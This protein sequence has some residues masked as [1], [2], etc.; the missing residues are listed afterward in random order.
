MKV[1]CLQC[2]VNEAHRTLS[3]EPKDVV[4][5][6]CATEKMRILLFSL[7]DRMDNSKERKMLENIHFQL[8]KVANYYEKNHGF[9]PF[10]H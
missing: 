4:E 7:I 8:E 10:C 3:T 9:K 1:D 2:I 6:F 5:R